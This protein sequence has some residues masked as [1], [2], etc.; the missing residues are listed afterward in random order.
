ME[1]LAKKENMKVITFCTLP[2]TSE[3]WKNKKNITHEILKLL[4]LSI[5]I[6]HACYLHKKNKDSIC[7]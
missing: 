3:V 5:F 7:L 2:F 6:S 4:I 1:T